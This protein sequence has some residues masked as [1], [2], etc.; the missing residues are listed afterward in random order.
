VPSIEHLGPTDAPPTSPRRRGCSTGPPL[1]A[2]PPCHSVETSTVADPRSGRPPRPQEAG[3]ACWIS[4]APSVTWRKAG[5]TAAVSCCGADPG[6]RPGSMLDLVLRLRSS[7]RILAWNAGSV[8]VR[9]ANRPRDGPTTRR[10]PPR[11]RQA[12]GRRQVARQWSA[13]RVLERRDPS[14][15]APELVEARSW[16]KPRAA[17]PRAID[18]IADDR[19]R[20][21][22]IR[23][24]VERR[25]G[26]S[27]PTPGARSSAR[28]ARRHPSPEVARVDGDD[29][30]RG[31]DVHLGDG[32]GIGGPAWRALAERRLRAGQLG[33][34]RSRIRG[35]RPTAGTPGSRPLG[36][37][38]PADPGR[39]DGASPARRTR[40][41]G[42]PRRPRHL[43]DGRRRRV[44]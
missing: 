32:D 5:R 21:G 37:V 42:R 44:P 28:M 16:A 41:A 1:E 35:R 31:I 18:R 22:G 7:W 8:R 23:S 24:P 13:P 36:R 26:Q 12:R 9:A 43:A 17:S 10:R 19:L 20:E 6:G 14:R 30:R 2:G 27:R 38:Q 39:V 3:D 4:A 29:R 33:G 11:A 15:P 34:R 40:S 25:V